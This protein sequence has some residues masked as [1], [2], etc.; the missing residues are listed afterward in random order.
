MFIRA[1]EKAS[2]GFSGN[3]AANFVDGFIGDGDGGGGG[4]GGRYKARRSARMEKGKRG[5]KGVNVVGRRCDK[6]TEWEK[7]AHNAP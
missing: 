1:S 6:V 2:V 4:G 5:R 7:T 3:R